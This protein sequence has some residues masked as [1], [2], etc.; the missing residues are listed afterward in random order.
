M[1]HNGSKT[2]PLKVRSNLNLWHTFDTWQLVT[3]KKLHFFQTWIDS[4][5][6]VAEISSLA[7][8][9]LVLRSKFFS[10]NAYFACAF[11]SN[12]GWRLRQMGMTPCICRAEEMSFPDV[13]TPFLHNL[14]TWRTDEHRCDITPTLIRFQ[15]ILRS[16]QDTS[17]Q[18]SCWRF[19]SLKH[20]RTHDYANET[21][22]THLDVA[23]IF[24]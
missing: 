22:Q 1:Y 2:L 5:T 18:D 17:L 4:L 24:N 8:T 7:S 16:T 13:S 20:K 14:R 11:P 19:L 21:L 15:R 23:I 10:A 9:V 12:L 6:T 3:A